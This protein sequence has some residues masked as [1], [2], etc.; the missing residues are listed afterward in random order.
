MQLKSV[1]LAM[2]TL[3]AV[4]AAS[5]SAHA[6]TDVGTPPPAIANHKAPEWFRDAKFGIFVHWGLYSVPGFAPPDAKEMTTSGVQLSRNPYA[7]WYFNSLHIP[8]SPT[9][10]FHKNAYGAATDYYSFRAAFRAASADWNADRW[11][12]IFK[13]AGARYSVLTTKHHDGYQL[14]PSAVRNPSKS[15][16]EITNPRDL[17]GQFT[18]AMR[19]QG[20][21]VGLYYSSLLDWSVRPQTINNVNE[22]SPQSAPQEA[23]YAKYVDAQWRELIARY[24]PDILWSDIGYPAKGDAYGVVTDYLKAVPDGVIDNRWAPF[25][26]GDYPTP[27]YSKFEKTASDPW[28]MTRGIGKS[29]GLNRVEPVADSLTGPGLIELLVD[30]VSKNGNLLLDVGPE[31]DGSLRAVDVD[32]LNTIGDWLSKDGE[33]IYGTRPFTRFGDTLPGGARVRYTTRG[34]SLYVVFLDAPGTG[35]IVLRN[36]GT[37]R[38]ATLLAGAKSI[39]LSVTGEGVSLTIPAEDAGQRFL[40]IRLE[41]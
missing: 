5:P 18:I 21:R 33:A 2:V 24:K 40:A 12:E 39:P 8:G 15:A 10:V 41:P 27:E 22:V 26:I 32:R 37:R 7:E 29:F 23:S 6:Q 38:K 30:V 19:R 14:W 20:I 1:S 35:I 3:T 36:I 31:P 11:A 28:E 4:L 16:E 34:H 9:S 13:R 25:K 17:V